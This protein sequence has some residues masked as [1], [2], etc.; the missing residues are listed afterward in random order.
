MRR[1]LVRAWPI[2]IVA[3]SAVLTVVWVGALIWML[4]TLVGFSGV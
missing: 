1:K 2:F 3:V 4:L